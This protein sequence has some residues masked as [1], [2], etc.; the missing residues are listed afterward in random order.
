MRCFNFSARYTPRVNCFPAESAKYESYHVTATRT[1]EHHNQAVSRCL[2]SKL[3]ISGTPLRAARF[4]VRNIS[5]DSSWKEHTC[6]YR[7]RSTDEQL[8]SMLSSCCHPS[9]PPESLPRWFHDLQDSASTLRNLI[10]TRC[11]PKTNYGQ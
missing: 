2:E 6:C 10:C 5:A 9:N 8:K 4:L 7:R 3:S 1:G 11:S